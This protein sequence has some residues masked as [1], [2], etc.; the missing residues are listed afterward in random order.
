MPSPDAD[1]E[2]VAWLLLSV[3]TARGLRAAVMP[4]CLELG[5]TALAF[6]VVP[7]A[8]DTFERGTQVTRDTE[9]TEFD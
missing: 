8:A 6:G 5:V 4:A 2:A 7:A 9:V 1:P 3:L